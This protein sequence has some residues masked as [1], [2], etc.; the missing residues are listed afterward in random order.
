MTPVTKTTLPAALRKGA[1]S[2]GSPPS[3]ATHRYTVPQGVRVIDLVRADLVN[4]PPAGLPPLTPL[5]SAYV[6]RRLTSPLESYEECHR[7]IGATA[8][9]QSLRK[10]A[11]VISYFEAAAAFHDPSDQDPSDLRRDAIRALARVVREGDGREVPMAAKVLQDYLPKGQGAAEERIAD[12]TT[13]E[14]LAR[15]EEVL[16]SLGDQGLRML[17]ALRLEEHRTYGRSPV[18]LEGTAP[19]PPPSQGPIIEVDVEPGGTEEG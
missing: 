8:R 16:G 6:K 1:A 3:P 15:L 10:S 12:L 19:P 7:Q 17:T 11:K 2:R 9:T 14:V 18:P 13:D 5:Q 4:S